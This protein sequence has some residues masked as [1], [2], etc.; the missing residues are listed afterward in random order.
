MKLAVRTRPCIQAIFV[1]VLTAT[2]GEGYWGPMFGLS[3]A[4]Q[5]VQ[6]LVPAWRHRA[7]LDVSQVLDRWLWRRWP[8][9]CLSAGAGI[10]R[11]AHKCL[12]C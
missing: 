4:K 11:H 2:C 8:V 7:G 1:L 10:L 5:G 6:G 12:F 9:F 3:A